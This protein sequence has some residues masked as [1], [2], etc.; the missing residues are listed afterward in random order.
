[1]NAENLRQA[2]KKQAKVH[3]LI[4]AFSRMEPIPSEV[5]RMPPFSQASL[6][7]S[8]LG[9]SSSDLPVLR[10]P[11]VL[12]PWVKSIASFALPYPK[13]EEKKLAAVSVA[14]FCAFDWY[15]YLKEKLSQIKARLL[16]QFPGL[17]IKTMVEGKLMEKFWAEKAGI[18]HRAKNSL[19]CHPRFGSRI[20][21]GELLLNVELCEENVPETESP[22]RECSL[23]LEACPTK[24]ITYPYQV[25]GELCL[26]FFTLHFHG[27]LPL[28]IR[29]AMGT[30]LFGCCTCQDCCPLNDHSGQ[31]LSLDRSRFPAGPGP[32]VP[33]REALRME[34]VE[35]Q[36]H[37]SGHTFKK[38]PWIIFKR[39]ALVACGNSLRIDLWDQILPFTAEDLPLI[40]QHAVWS[41]WRINAK[42]ARPLL[43]RL[44]QQES[45]LRVKKE[46]EYLLTKKH[47]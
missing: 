14:A 10:N 8:P 22:C 32:Y 45:N 21:L 1:M 3:G 16:T 18:G 44:W 34:E 29:L 36:R 35:F 40:R 4:V 27:V 7:F 42:K 13:E 15:G 26:D 19:I 46:I 47:P 37:F 24:A 38:I 11:Q 28:S 20:L 6:L 33:F 23:C 41:L 12:F 25:Q 43:Y 39:N 17:R 9:W 2:I 31:E 30:R 5:E